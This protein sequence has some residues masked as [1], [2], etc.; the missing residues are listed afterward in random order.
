MVIQTVRFGEI[1]I[2]DSSIIRLE[3][4]LLGFP[5]HQLFCLLEGKPGS[6]FRWLQSIERAALAFLVINPYEFFTDYEIYLDD[7]TA[8]AMDLSK[9]EEA[10]VLALVSVQEGKSLTANLVGPVIVNT[11]TGRGRQLV[12]DSERYCTRH[13]I[14]R[15]DGQQAAATSAA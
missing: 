10:G 5:E 12:L 8:S 11:R 9:P 6:P 4:G 7:D 14:A 1:E 13:L 15:R 3:E 2:D